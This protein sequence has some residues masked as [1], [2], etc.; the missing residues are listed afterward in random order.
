MQQIIKQ[1]QDE[2]TQL[3]SEKE[4]NDKK[5]NEDALILQQLTK[6]TFNKDI[7]PSDEN[8]EDKPV[9]KPAK[10]KNEKPT[11]VVETKENPKAEPAKGKKEEWEEGP[12]GLKFRD[13]RVGDGKIVKQGSKVTVFYV[14][15]LPNQKVF[16][17]RINGEGF[18]FKVGRGE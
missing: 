16:D 6:E 1:Q 8:N 14:G 11:K 18:E 5:Q 4:L 2:I 3:K 17:K 9:E 7:L 12:E 15:Q 10:K 13:L